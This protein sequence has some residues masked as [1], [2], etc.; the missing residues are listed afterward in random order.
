MLGLFLW[1]GHQG[2]NLADE[3]YLWYGVQRVMVGEVPLRDFSS[4][5]PG[6]YYL[7]AA[8]MW[9]WGDGGIVALRAVEAIVQA[10]GLF[11]ALVLL[12]RSLPKPSFLFLLVATVTLAVWMFPRN[13]FFDIT[14]SIALVGA[15]SFLI[16]Q[17]SSRRYLLAGLTVGLAAVIGRNH[18]LYGLVGSLFALVYLGLRPATRPGLIR[19]LLA[20]GAGIVLGYLP[21]LAMIV[22]VPGYLP[23]FW[24]TIRF[25]FQYGATN[26]PLPVPWPWHVPVGQLPLVDAARGL[27]PGF[28]FMGLIAYGVL[29]ILWVAWQRLRNRAVPPTLAASAFMALPYAHFAFSRP[30]VSHLAQASFPFLIGC[31]VLLAD[32]PA[33]VR[34][35]LAALLCGASLFVALPMHPGWQCRM[36]LPCVAGDI[37]GSRLMIEPW[38]AAD[39]AM[40]TQLVEQFAR[41]IAASLWCLY[42]RAPMRSGGESPPF[43]TSIQPSPEARLSRRRR[44]SESKPQI[45]ALPSSSTILSTA[46]RRC[47]SAIPIRSSMLI[48]AITSTP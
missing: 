24:A 45:P 36:I 48:S 31:L 25:L 11:I 28:F 15:L 27:V 46:G 32:R 20:W 14:T 43:G 10:L 41:A 38:S 34:C 29:G 21:I 19:G 33:W 30:D 40:L 35:S 37:S 16:Q 2:F 12:Q 44:S 26:L 18:G 17:P 6:R 4:Y 7:S 42:R 8:L 13:K 5:D 47:A 9:L 1:Q 22:V 39:I 23:G 3:G